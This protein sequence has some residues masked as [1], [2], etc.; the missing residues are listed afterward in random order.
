[1]IKDQLC[2]HC[3]NTIPLHVQLISSTRK[4]LTLPSDPML[5]LEINTMQQRLAY[6]SSQGCD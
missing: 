4:R 2:I 6:L 3:R 5:E 1:M